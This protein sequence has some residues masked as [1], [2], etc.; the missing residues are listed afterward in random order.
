MNDRQRTNTHSNTT[1][2][3]DGADGPD[4]GTNRAPAR[5]PTHAAVMPRL[6]SLLFVPGNK[7][8]MLARALG[9]PADA[10]VPDM[11]DSVPDGEK[12]AARETISAFLP[13]LLAGPL[14]IPRVN[15]L[16]SEWFEDDV[17]AMVVP[18]VYGISIG[19]VESA[20]DIHA[21]AATMSRCER[22]AGIAEGTLR[23]IPWIETARGIVHAHA[24]CSADA[25]VV[26]AAF[27]GEDFAHDMAVERQEGRAQF[28]VARSIL[29]IAARAADVLALETPYFRFRDEAGLRE[30]ARAARL[31][32]FRGRFAIHPAQV[33]AINETF[34]PGR[35]EIEWARRVV[36]AFEAAEQVGRGSTSLDGHVIDV[37]VVKRARAVLAAAAADMP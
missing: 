23:L 34:S 31:A 37:P 17:A 11:E 29:C 28:A 30:D 27:G 2:G 26:A 8:N 32:G 3:A 22:R 15:P 10:L 19:K 24:I 14:V 7:A 9:C 5:A 33:Q 36:A 18:G 6:R 12:P 13:Q 4:S 20:A 16:H 21:I 25:R 35:E 1:G